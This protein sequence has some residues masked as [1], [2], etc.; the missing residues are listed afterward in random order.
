MHCIRYREEKAATLV[1]V[2]VATLIS[3]VVLVS[4]IQLLVFSTTLSRTAGDMSKATTEVISKVE[5]M[6]NHEY[7]QLLTDYGTGTPGSI[8]IS[9]GT[10]DGAG[11]ISM[12]SSNAH[13]LQATLGYSW[14]DK[15]GRLFGEDADLDGV[16]DAGEDINGNGVLDFGLTITTHFAR[17]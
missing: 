6:R 3:S 16:L 13:L 10:F 9:S 2:L 14:R 1:E 5:E 4:M 12:D 11:V 7:S 17:R 8:F 15:N